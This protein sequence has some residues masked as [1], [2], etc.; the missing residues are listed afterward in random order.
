M[1]DNIITGSIYVQP[2][3]FDDNT[4]DKL[5]NDI[6]NLNYI[7]TYQPDTYY[8]NRMQAF[9]CYETEFKVDEDIKSSFENLLN[10]QVD[11]IK[12]IARKIITDELNQSVNN[13]NKYGFIHRD[14]DEGELIACMMYFDQ[15][16]DGGTAFFENHW[17]NV[18]DMYVSAYPNRLVMYSGKRWHAP[19]IDYTFKERK[20]LS[21]FIKVK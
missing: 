14:I 4:F 17:D 1:F 20:T 11:S 21:Y 2:N 18:P 6:N 7:E 9:P 5:K 15:S 19:S 12:C 8:G 13:F 3:F 16:F 10:K